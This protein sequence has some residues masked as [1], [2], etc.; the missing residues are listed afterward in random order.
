MRRIT[1]KLAVP[2]AAALAVLSAAA[3]ATAVQAAPAAYFV[4]TDITREEFVVQLT[5]PAKIR[6]ARDLVN[7]ET[8]DRPHVVGRILKRPAP[9]NPRWSYHYNSDTVDFFDAAIEVCDAT[10][11]YVEDH[12]DE[13][14]GAFLP[15]LVFCPW[16]S[17][18][19][20]ELPA[21]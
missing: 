2:L 4:M 9:Y 3:P 10:I 14:G 8:L 20:R 19:V 13:A 16:T 11:P 17:R 12:L 6:H 5:D 7:G 18:L 1:R 21:P 15:G